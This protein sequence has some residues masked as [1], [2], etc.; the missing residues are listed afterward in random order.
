MTTDTLEKD[1]ITPEEKIKLKKSAV[2]K[3]KKNLL[4]TT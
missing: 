1:T 4:E 2:K 3:I